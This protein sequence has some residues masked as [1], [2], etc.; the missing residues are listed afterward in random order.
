MKDPLHLTEKEVSDELWKWMLE[1]QCIDAS[2]SDAT[3][4]YEQVIG[5]LLALTADVGGLTEDV[6]RTV[7]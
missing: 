7:V 4:E 1:Q 2:R 6:S 3:K 5:E